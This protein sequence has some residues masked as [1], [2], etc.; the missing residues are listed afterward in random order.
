MIKYSHKLEQNNAYL[1]KLSPNGEIK[2]LNGIIGRSSASTFFIYLTEIGNYKVE[3]VSDFPYT[4]DN[5]NTLWSHEN[6]FDLA[7][8]LFMDKIKEDIKCKKSIIKTNKSLL[9][10]IRK[11]ESD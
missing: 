9:K 5:N 3:Y 4:I 6:D 11:Q 1:Y 8:C 10:S 2:T 7:K